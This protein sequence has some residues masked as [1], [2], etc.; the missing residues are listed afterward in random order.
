MRAVAGRLGVEAMSLY[1]HVPSKQ[2]MI[3]GLVDLLVQVA[4]LPTGH[5]TAE[6]WIRAAGGWSRH[7]Q[8]RRVGLSSQGGGQQFG[9]PGRARLA[10]AHRGGP[11]R[12]T[13]AA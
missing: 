12:P 9:R 1:H 5:T 11:S 2:A 3:D 6:E 13:E 8:S 7:R 4:A 10:A